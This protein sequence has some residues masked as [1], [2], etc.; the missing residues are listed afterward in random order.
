[1]LLNQPQWQS[2]V[3]LLRLWMEAQVDGPPIWRGKVQHLISGEAQRFDDWSTLI[4]ALL[5]LLPSQPEAESA[6]S[7]ASTDET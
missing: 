2:Q 4:D 7:V 3:F 5:A 1:V 6:H